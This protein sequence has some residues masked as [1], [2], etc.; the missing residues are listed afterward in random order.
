MRRNSCPRLLGFNLSI[1]SMPLTT[2]PMALKRA[3]LELHMKQEELRRHLEGLGVALERPKKGIWTSYA[4]TAPHRVLSLS[5][6]KS[7]EEHW[8]MEAL[9]AVDHLYIAR[10]MVKAARTLSLR[11]QSHF[12][13]WVDD[14][15]IDLPTSLL[16]MHITTGFPRDTWME[17]A[18]ALSQ[19]YGS[20][21]AA[22][23]SAVSK[24]ARTELEQR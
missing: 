6:L 12:N 19:R 16:R 7:T 8:N 17:E 18:R 20:I 24:Q 1:G 3:F 23:I 9:R 21:S 15:R 4:I 11:D 10:A 14:L 22:D 2:R 5:T 13:A